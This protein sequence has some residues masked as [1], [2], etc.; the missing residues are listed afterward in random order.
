[1]LYYAQ[2]AFIWTAFIGIHYIYMVLS[3]ITDR[4]NYKIE[5]KTQCFVFELSIPL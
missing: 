1:M 2:H 4:N 5:K 3:A